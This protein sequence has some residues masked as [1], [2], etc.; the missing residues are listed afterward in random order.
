[1]LLCAV[2]WM[3]A[4]G[5]TGVLLPDARAEMVRLAP[6]RGGKCRSRESSRWTRGFTLI[7]LLVVIAIIAILA[8][9]LLPALS[10]AKEKA[11]VIQCM[12]NHRQLTLTWLLYA[13]DH[14]DRLVAN[15]HGNADS[16]HGA[17]LWVVGDTHLR[18]EAFTNTQ[19]LIDPAYASFA[20][21]LQAPKIYKCPSD[22]S[23][24]E[25]G[26]QNFPRA[27]SYSLNSYMGWEHPAGFGLLSSRYWLFRKHSD[28]ALGNPSE[29]LTFLDVAPGNI[30]NSGFV[31]SLG[32]NLPGLFY[33][34]PSAEHRGAGV[35]SFADGHV[36]S[37]R[38]LDPV[39]SRLAREKWIPNHIALQFPGNLDLD[40]IR[41]RASVRK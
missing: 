13:S 14:E 6:N 11:R 22:R 24:V 23:T 15:G 31:I 32:T 29:L 37:K 25:I 8:A 5:I 7:E 35:V 36:T 38:W 21:Y 26:D 12:S 34:L 1:M 9:L 30:C 10:V 28:L 41:Q 17:R 2:L 3:T 27:R 16:L 4:A 20:N 39:T 40:W 19:Y 33:H 18:R